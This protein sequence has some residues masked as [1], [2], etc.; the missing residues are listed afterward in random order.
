MSLQINPNG[1]FQNT[2]SLLLQPSQIA[3]QPVQ[4][5]SGM[6]KLPSQQNSP[7]NLIS[8]LAER[9]DRLTQMVSNLLNSLSGTTTPNSNPMAGTAPIAAPTVPTAPTA[10]VETP[11]V[12]QETTMPQA[13]ISELATPQ[14]SLVDRLVGFL[15]NIVDRLLGAILGDRQGSGANPSLTQDKSCGLGGIFK[16][17]TD[18]FSGGSSGIF[19]GITDIFGGGASGGIGGAVSGI[20]KAIKSIF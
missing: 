18:I 3:S 14:G 8:M 1:I 17:I 4:S 9:L 6:I 20:G 13:G 7:M 5:L 2:Q 10:A 15:M 19:K 11:A 16:G 12:T